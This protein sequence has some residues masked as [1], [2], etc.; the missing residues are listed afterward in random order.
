MRVIGKM[1]VATWLLLS[2]AAAV[3][4]GGDTRVEHT[5]SVTVRAIART[6][7]ASPLALA[8]AAGSA[9]YVEKGGVATGSVA[10]VVSSDQKPADTTLVPTR[11]SLACPKTRRPV[12]PSNGGVGNA[13]V[14][15]AG[16]AAGRANDIPRRVMITLQECELQ[17]RVE[18]VAAGGTIIVGSRD[19]MM[20]RL[21]FVAADTGAS[22]DSLATVALNDA[23]Q[24]VPLSDASRAP[25]L[26]SIHDE[27][28]PWVRGYLA[29]APHP[30]VA[31]T[32]P[33]GKFVFTDVP[34]GTYTLV[35]W[36][37]RFGITTQQV[38]VGA[39]QEARVEVTLK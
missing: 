34:A 29:V 5:D 10:G 11:D 36:H 2:S 19:K 37:E 31:V 9:A 4:C 21:R 16:V 38:V 24:V 35:T 17:P 15:L 8:N 25:G 33:D 39:G 22:P 14:W 3:S 6:V 20:S 28:H 13:V 27:L 26:V 18:R 23:G 12:F 32:A 30:F 1:R 7:S